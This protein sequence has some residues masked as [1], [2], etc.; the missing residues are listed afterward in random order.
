MRIKRVKTLIVLKIVLGTWKSPINV[1]HYYFYFCFFNVT[2]LFCRWETEA[3]KSVMTVPRSHTQPFY[4]STRKVGPLHIF[5]SG[6]VPLN[7]LLSCADSMRVTGME[8][9]GECNSNSVFAIHLY[10]Q[11]R[12]VPL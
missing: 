5:Y 11:H 4:I 12:C 1:G 8:G 10:T 7:V 6:R 2:P 3:Q 9:G